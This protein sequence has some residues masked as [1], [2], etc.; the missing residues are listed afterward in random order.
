MHLVAPLPPPPSA[1]SYGPLKSLTPLG[2]YE[3]AGERFCQYAFPNKQR[4]AIKGFG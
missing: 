3:N 2:S 1:I 4:G